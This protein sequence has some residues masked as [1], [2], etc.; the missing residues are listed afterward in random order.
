MPSGEYDAVS[1]TTTTS[2]MIAS[3][4]AVGSGADAD[5]TAPGESVAGAS[6]AAGPAEPSAVADGTGIGEFVATAGLAP[7][8]GVTASEA[9]AP[10]D[11]A[12]DP[13]G[14][15]SG[16]GVPVASTPDALGLP[17]GLSV[18]LSVADAVALGA[19]GADPS[20]VA[21]GVAG[22]TDVDGSLDTTAPDGGGGVGTATTMMLPPDPFLVEVG[23]TT[24]CLR[25][26]DR[27]TV[28]S[29]LPTV[30]NRRGE[31]AAIGAQSGLALAGQTWSMLAKLRL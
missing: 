15:A 10:G 20:G 31:D 16:I 24:S 9:V 25:E 4:P 17:V 7:S 3:A 1:P 19:S 21:S 29:E 27:M 5:G 26:G 22:A 18:G 23:T 12:G 8:D 2:L 6:V 14:D 11:P 13:S 30:G 28:C